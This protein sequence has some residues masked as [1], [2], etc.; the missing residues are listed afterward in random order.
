M[1]S[2]S[3]APTLQGRSPP[4]P[5]QWQMISRPPTERLDAGQEWKQSEANRKLDT[6]MIER[7]LQKEPVSGE[8]PKAEALTVEPGRPIVRSSILVGGL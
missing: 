3:K 8:L 6:E 2:E 7:V 1:R 5:G 4:E